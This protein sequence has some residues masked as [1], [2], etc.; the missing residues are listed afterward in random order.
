M[1]KYINPFTDWGF[2]R[3]F[4]QEFSKD[5]LID[6]LNDLFVDELCIK[7]VTF[8]DKEQLPETKDLRGCVFDIYCETDTGEHFIVEMQNNYV[9]L[10]VNRTIYYA[11]KAI[12]AQRE[13]TKTQQHPTLYDLVPVYVVCFMNFMPKE[14]EEDEIKKFKTDVMLYDKESKDIFSDKLRFI[15]LR[16][17]LFDKKTEA[18]CI[19]NFDKWIYVLKHMEALTRMPFTAQ[20]KIFK[21][22]AELADSRSLTKEEQEKYDESRKIADD[23]YSGLAGSFMA[24]EKAGIKKGMEKGIEKGIAK[25]KVATAKR[26]LTMG[27]TPE[28]VA[29]GSELPLAEVLRLAQGD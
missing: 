15:Y 17:P 16:I 10:F 13:K 8:K 4:G 24:G 12:V 22:L 27:L 9:P 28:Q 21:R 2:K 14:G 20:K 26:L 25:N 11:S 7:D 5:L 19:T 29:Q 23:Y 3:L 18:E 1:S 6:F